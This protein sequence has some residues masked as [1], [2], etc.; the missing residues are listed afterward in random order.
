LSPELE[1]LVSKL[2]I[3][4]DLFILD[5]LVFLHINGHIISDLLDL[6]SLLISDGLM[7]MNIG[8]LLLGRALLNL[9]NEL[10]LCLGQF[11]DLLVVLVQVYQLVFP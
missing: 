7:L 9:F 5:T 6:D 2:G 1:Q 10:L 11:N 4:L 3:L 8:Q